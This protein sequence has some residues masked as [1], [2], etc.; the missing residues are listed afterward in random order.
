MNSCC[1]GQHSSSRIILNAGHPGTKIARAAAVRAAAANLGLLEGQP[2]IQA[3]AKP[4][5]LLVLL[6]DPAQQRIHHL[7]QLR[8]L[9][10]VLNG[11]ILGQDS[12][13]PGLLHTDKKLHSWTCG[14]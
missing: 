13:L 8:A 6:R 4:E 7:L 14:G 10:A 12:I 5:S 1:K 11:L 3:I 9:Q 2:A